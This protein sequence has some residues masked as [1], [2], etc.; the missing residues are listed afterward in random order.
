VTADLPAELEPMYDVLEALDL[1]PRPACGGIR[2]RCPVHEAD[3]QPHNPSFT[4]FIGRDDEPA[5]KCHAGCETRDVWRALRGAGVPETAPGGPR[6]RRPSLPLAHVQSVQ[7]WDND[8]PALGAWPPDRSDWPKDAA[9]YEH[10]ASYKYVNLDN[11][12]MGVRDRYHFLD[13]AGDRI[14]KTFR[15]RSPVTHFD[16]RAGRDT[17][18]WAAPSRAGVTLPLFGLP[19]LL[20]RIEGAPV[21]VTEGEKDALALS[22]HGLCAVTAPDGASGWRPIHTQQLLN[23]LLPREVVRLAGDADTAGADWR[24]CLIHE[25]AADVTV[26][27]MDHVG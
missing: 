4:A 19:R 2:A 1:D 8:S 5:V 16:R 27:V 15:Q 9:R 23:A 24:E 18:R 3:G 10:V 22:R 25:L 26:E 14:G 21:Y 20:D 6:V 11:E 13:A 17:V 12:L 7:S